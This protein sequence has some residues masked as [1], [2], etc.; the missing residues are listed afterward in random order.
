MNHFRLRNSG[1]ALRGRDGLLLASIFT[2]AVFSSGCGEDPHGGPRVEVVPVTGKVLVDGKPAQGVVV[3]FLRSS[4]R[5]VDF[6]VPEPRGVTDE[7]GVLSLSTYVSNDGGAPGEY[8][9][10]FEWLRRVNPLT[11]EAQ[12]DEFR[13]KYMTTK[14]ASQFTA[15]IPE[16]AGDEP[17]NIG[18]FEL[19]TKQE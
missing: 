13:G 18:T 17:H 19:T 16:E 12:G 6:V 2:L 4:E 7:N 14:D 1:S 15:T 9:L 3:Y 11:G 5:G 8:K 10:L